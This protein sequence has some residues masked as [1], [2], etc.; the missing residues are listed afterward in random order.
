MIKIVKDGPIGPIQLDLKVWTY[1][2]GEIG[3]RLDVPN[4]RWA[5]ARTPYQTI[6]YGP[7][8]AADVITLIMV[9]DA[10]R[11]LD[12]TPIRLF[13]PYCPYG[14]QDRV[15]VPG[16]AHSLR[17]FSDL[18][19]GLDLESVTVLDPHSSVT[20]AV[21]DRLTIISQKD[22]VNR[23]EGLRDHL[24]RP[25]VTLISPDA[26]SNKKVSELA[27][28]LGHRSFVRAD[29]LRNLETG[30]II[31]T[32]VYADDLEGRTAVIADDV[33]DGSGTFIALAKVLK[34]KG[35]ARV[36]LYVT[37]GIWSKGLDIVFAGGIDEVWCT[38]SFRTDIVGPDGHRVV[39][40]LR[41]ETFLT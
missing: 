20:E 14:R 17:V 41:A 34:A 31:E 9:V 35:A 8:S 22:I 13:M 27:G 36:V 7:Q 19:N 40:V 39:Q 11:R 25:N 29:K 23:W 10:L 16:E 37:H 15:C 3:V 12:S 24:A 5:E 4:P 26:G 38:D 21:F 28:Y 32:V 30:A 6:I 2:A 18:I 33:A 1:P